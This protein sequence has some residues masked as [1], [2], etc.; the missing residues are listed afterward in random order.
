MRKYLN[1]FSYVTMAGRYK[2]E[3]NN[4]IIQGENL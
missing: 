3:Y 4:S 2:W 1:L